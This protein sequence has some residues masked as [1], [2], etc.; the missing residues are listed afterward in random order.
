MRYF[1]LLI[2]LSNTFDFATR[3]SLL[4]W[5][6]GFQGDE[7]QQLM[8]LGLKETDATAFHTELERNGGLLE[9]L[10]CGFSVC[11]LVESLHANSSFKVCDL[12]S[13]TISKWGGGQGCKTGGTYFQHDVCWI[14]ARLA[15]QDAQKWLLA[16]FEA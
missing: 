7:V 8:T 1:V 2:D 13:F 3:E 9:F 11:E 10:G 15:R 14:F 4:S 12:D 6:Q 16:P 5:R